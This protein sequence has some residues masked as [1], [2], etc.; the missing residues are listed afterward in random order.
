MKKIATATI[1]TAGF[2]TIAIASGNQAHA[3]EQDNYGYNPNDPTSYSY[4]YTIDAQGN[5]HYTWKGNWHPSQLNQDNG[6]YS[7]YYYNGYNNYNNYNT[8]SYRTGGLGA[9]YSTSSNNVQVT[10]TM[11]PSSNGRSISSGYTSGRN[12]YTSGQ[13]TYYVFDR[14]GGKIGSTWGNASNWANAA[15]RAGYTVNNTP[16][17]GAIMQT[18]QG[19]Y[20]HVAYVESVNSNGSVRVSEMNYGYGPGVVTSRTISASQAAGYNFIH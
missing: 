17:A 16:K 11:A 9:S 15:A 3:S 6:Y 19:A 8:N 18:T 14:V 12:L 2:A 10:T 20:G 7:Y 4:T 1:A 13:C 5:Y